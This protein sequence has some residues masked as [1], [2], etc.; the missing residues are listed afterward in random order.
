M[1]NLTLED[2]NEAIIDEI[3]EFITKK[4]NEEMDKILKKKSKIDSAIFVISN[5]KIDNCFKIYQDCLKAFLNDTK[6][7]I[8]EIKFFTY[9]TDDDCFLSYGLLCGLYC[10]F[11]E[12]KETI[13]ENFNIERFPRI[14]EVIKGY[15]DV[16]KLKNIYLSKLKSFTK[17]NLK[18]NSDGI[19]RNWFKKIYERNKVKSSNEV[20]N[21]E[22]EI[23]LEDDKI[24]N[25]KTNENG[26]SI[27]DE[28]SDDKKNYKI[29]K[30]ENKLINYDNKD[31]ILDENKSKDGENTQAEET[32]SQNDNK[33]ET[34]LAE[35]KSKKEETIKAE[36]T[37]SQKVGSKQAD[38]SKSQNEETT[39]TEEAKSQNGNSQTEENKLQNDN[40]EE[41]KQD[42]N[43]LINN[44]YGQ[45]D[46]ID[47]NNNN[48][49]NL[50]NHLDKNKSSFSSNE[51][52]MYEMLTIFQK[53]FET[54]NQKFEIVNNELKETKKNSE[55][56][57]KRFDLLQKNQAL[58]LT[59]ISLYQNSRDNG[60]SIF[61]YLHKYFGLEESQTHFEK[62]KQVFNYLEQKDDTSKIT[63][64]QKFIL[65]KFLKI[66]FF[67]NRY[68]NKILH[69]QLK[70]T[71]KSLISEVQKKNKDLPSV[72]PEFNYKQFM[73]SLKD[74]IKDF[75]KN[76]EIQLA[77]ND[78]YDNY[79]KDTELGPIFDKDKEAIS[80]VNKEIEFKI[81]NKEIDEA[82]NFLNNLKID[83]ET[84]ESL[85]DKTSWDK[86]N[87]I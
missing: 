37:I 79:S 64:S 6:Y 57:S 83:G 18:K 58:L 78:V 7:Q 26:N 9:I 46:K 48:I 33:N 75:S 76:Q 69:K 34:I 60:K 81:E 73:V 84:L 82:I 68:H 24:K 86:S 13:F 8:E 49:Y 35:N 1:D 77:L 52:T 32:I 50:M 28:L 41:N 71:T 80:L 45:K 51:K 29:L 23:E 11:K 44:S 14:L 85:C 10:M 17:D 59:Q 4:E 62:T 70:S 21:K 87:Q 54:I 15:T 42:N 27:H 40:K 12:E 39:F 25:E 20:E 56:L 30:E 2:L 67:V 22:E 63:R 16:T 5:A 3:I 47:M 38:D 31:T 65:K 53:N 66:M 19:F 61:L 74:F 43:F 36:E 72:F 55:E